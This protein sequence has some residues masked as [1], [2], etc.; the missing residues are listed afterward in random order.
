MVGPIAGN[1]S[2][3]PGTTD[4]EYDELDVRCPPHTTERKMIS[5]IDWRLVPFL[6]I[7]YL[8]AFLDRVNIANARSFHLLE[9]LHITR[10]LDYNTG[11]HFYSQE[12]RLILRTLPYITSCPYLGWVAGLYITLLTVRPLLKQP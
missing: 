6:C 10:E 11:K 2:Y 12:I 4:P 7:L 3:H 8:L 1:N 5:R 9:D